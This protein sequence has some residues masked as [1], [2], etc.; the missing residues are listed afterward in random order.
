MKKIYF[1]TIRKNFLNYFLFSSFIAV[2]IILLNIFYFLNTNKTIETSLISE[3]D[4]DTGP[5]SYSETGGKLAIIIDDFGQNRDGV[6]E[7]MSI[8]RHIT[9][10]IMPFLSFSQSDAKT[11]HAKGFE[12]IVHLPMES[13][14]GNLNR[15]GP[16]PIMSVMSNVEVQ[17]LVMDT[18]DNVPFAVGANIHM[19]SKAG[20]DERII[21]NVLDII[22]SRNLYFVDSRAGRHPIAKAIADSKGVICYNRDVFLD[23]KQP[24][25]YIK[26]QLKKS[27]DIAL[28]MGSAVAIGHVG[29]EGGK[30]TAQSISEMLPEIDR[31]NISLVFVSELNK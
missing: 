18:F 28:K 30:V 17:Q 16:R 8:D 25:E 3:E 20:E 29:I 4:N 2:T 7:M 5:V 19:G 13:Y 6:K 11:A 31:R 22:K 27:C 15:V 24:K 9:L 26:K 23:R 10:A 12:V 1:V 21:S 14:K